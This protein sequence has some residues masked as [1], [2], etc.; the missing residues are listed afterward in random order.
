MTPAHIT[1]MGFE[2]VSAIGVGTLDKRD[3]R[4]A[5]DPKQIINVRVMRVCLW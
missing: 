4:K 1:I 5:S 3:N 2:Y